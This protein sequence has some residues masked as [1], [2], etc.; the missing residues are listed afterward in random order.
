MTSFHGRALTAALVLILAGAAAPAAA[1]PP[2]EATVPAAP[3][4][5]PAPAAEGAGSPGATDRVIVKFK[6][7]AEPAPRAR[8]RVYAEAAERIAP[9][10]AAAGEPAAAPL[11]DEIS[12]TVDSAR[13]VAADGLLDAEQLETLTG[14]LEEDPAV[15][16]AEPDHLAS[17]AAVPDDPYYATSQWNLQPAAAG[18]DL[19]SAWDRATGRGQ[20][21]AVV[22]TGI[23]SHPDLDANVAPGHDFVSLHAGGVQPGHSATGTAGTRTHGTRGTTPV[24]ASADPAP[25]PAPP[26]G[27]AR[28]R[29]AS[30]RRG[31]TTA[32]VWPVSPTARRSCRCAPSGPAGTGT[33]P[34]SPWRS[35]G[36]PARTSTPSR[37]TPT[38][39]PW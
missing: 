12:R 1:R 35:P 6:D 5:A 20:T 25:P 17:I 26:P 31:A 36:P 39:R 15:E 32:P 16:Y 13:V 8:E 14:A 27:T 7:G 30:R 23:T 33:C 28:T 4:P 22:D 21:I 9:G 11:L 34:T 19:P 2:A 18:L 3:A 37:R 29:R 10:G 38:R 24:P